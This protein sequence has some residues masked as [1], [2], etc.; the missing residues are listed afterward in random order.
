MAKFQNGIDLWKIRDKGQ[1]RNYV[2]YRRN[3]KLDIR[4]LKINYDTKKFKTAG[5]KCISADGV[6]RGKASIN[7]DD[8]EEVTLGHVSDT[9][10][11]LSKDPVIGNVDVHHDKCF[12]IK[13]K[14][15]TPDLDLVAEDKLTR[16][17]LVNLLNHLL[18]TLRSLEEQK[19]YEKFLRSKFDQADKNGSGEISLDE[20]ASLIDELNIKLPKGELER[21]FS[22]ANK[23][24]DLKNLNE[25]EFVNFFYNFCKIP[26]L[27][28]L[29][30]KYITPSSSSDSKAARM[31]VNELYQFLVTEQRMELSLEELSKCIEAFEPNV[32]KTTFSN[33]GFIQFMTFSDLNNIVDISRQRLVDQDM[34]QPLSHYWIASSHNTYLLGNQLTGESSVNAYINAL[35]QGCRCVELDC[36]DGPD[37][38]PKITHGWTQCTSILFK[39]V[40]ED[41][42]KIYA[43]KTTDYPL[44]LSI[45]NHCSLEQ[46]DV[47]ADHLKSLGDLLFADKVDLDR[48]HL[49]SP[50][51]LKRK[52]LIKAKK[53][54]PGKDETFEDVEEDDQDDLDEERRQKL[55]KK[56]SQKLSDCVNYIEAV[57]FH[58]FEEDGQFYQ[59]SSFGE[60][61][62]E[63]IIEDPENSKKFVK[64]NCRQISRIY[65]G[66][67]RQDSSNLNIIPFFNAGCQIVALNY[68]KDDNQNFY[69]RARFSVNGG[70]G[71]VLKPD[72][73]RNPSIPYSPMG[74]DCG[75]DET[76]YPPWKIELTIISGHYIPKPDSFRGEIID[77]YVKVRIKGHEADEK[78][79]NDDGEKFKKNKGETKPIDNNGF[80]PVWNEKF[81]FECKVPDLA[82]LEFKVKD[83]SKSGKDEELGAFCA[84]L[85]SILE[86]YR[87]VPLKTTSS[88]CTSSAAALLIHVLIKKQL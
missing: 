1:L 27:E 36:W 65:P 57:H 9:F 43:F 63:K 54:P 56:I 60:S 24:K 22:D 84:P 5:P 18:M 85:C 52:V 34:T 64:Y 82:L 47:M 19:K 41:A 38:E 76:S 33:E 37:G 32:D 77:P 78:G 21:L 71:Y 66:A 10:N 59:M 3:F 31:T 46:Q 75:L 61:K 81:N 39:D 55:S 51:D 8:I 68:Q 29:F 48:D 49:P 6:N 25:T 28:E 80:N 74:Q 15:N 2:T 83:H 44:I 23:D 72:F 40:I 42:I 17:E 26:E 79:I 4:D 30:I 87:R 14:D 16:D 88:S 7:L 11:G 50:E 69:N 70:C 12:T 13:F 20:C 58:G 45:E 73:L 62:A 53:L 35:K 86:G 67:K